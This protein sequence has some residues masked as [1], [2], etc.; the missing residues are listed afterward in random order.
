MET[1]V[2]PFVPEVTDLNPAGS[3][4]NELQSIINNN[5]A[6]G[7]EFVSLNSM[8]TSV[9]P[10]G[11]FGFPTSAAATEVNIQLLIFKK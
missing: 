7:W 4:A 3:A 11:C 1:K 5:A 9:K 2:I 6:E 8:Q 10:A